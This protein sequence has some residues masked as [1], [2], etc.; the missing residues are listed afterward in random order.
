MVAQ[1]TYGAELV[2][3]NL[4]GAEHSNLV[5]GTVNYDY[6]Y[7]TTSEISYFAALGLNVIR[8]PI[9]FNILIMVPPA[10]LSRLPPHIEGRKAAAMAFQFNE[11]QS[12]PRR[13]GGPTD[14]AEALLP[15]LERVS[16]RDSDLAAAAEIL[17][18]REWRHEDQRPRTLVAAQ[19]LAC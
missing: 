7:P 1:S 9:T 11:V 19:V 10:P 16:L 2:G 18:Q 14:H 17:L 5:T 12:Q 13:A 6:V 15:N 4:S 8:I 3:V